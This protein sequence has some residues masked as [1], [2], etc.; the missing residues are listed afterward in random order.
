[1][2]AVS[3]IIPA[4]NEQCEL[5]G[6]INAIHQAADAAGLDCEI[7]VANDNSSDQT[8]AI[9][10]AHGAQV[11]DVE[12]RQIAATRNSGAAAAT[13]SILIFVDADTRVTREVVLAAVAAIESGTAGGGAWVT[14]ENVPPSA[15]I[16]LWFVQRAMRLFRTTPGCFMFMTREAFDATGGYDEQFYASEE[17]WM[18]R[19]LR[20][21]G[22]FTLLKEHV[23]TSGRKV[24][25]HSTLRL[26]CKASMI[27]V[28]GTRAVKRREGLDLWYDG[29]REQPR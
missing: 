26:L 10:R 12:H 9:A 28:R 6:T 13:G 14:F 11:I 22:R 2:P 3:F 25:M 21:A 7:I 17:V 27:G 4:Y 19:A 15:H 1:M 29:E 20:R 23:I 8:A 18:S 5:P 24:R 16:L